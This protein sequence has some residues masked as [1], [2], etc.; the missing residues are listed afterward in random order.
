MEACFDD[1]ANIARAKRILVLL[2]FLGLMSFVAMQSDR[3]NYRECGPF[4]I[5]QSV[6]A[7]CDWIGR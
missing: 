1:C 7:G 2:I 3:F 6:I 5:G 4:T